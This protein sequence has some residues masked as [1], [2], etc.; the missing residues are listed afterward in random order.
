MTTSSELRPR[1]FCAAVL[2]GIFVAT[3]VFA[4]A[5]KQAHADEVSPSGKGIVG[6]ALLGAEVVTITESLIGVH[7]GWAYLAGA[8]VGGAGGGVGGYFIEQNS[9][10]GKAPVFILAGGLA[11][12]IPAVV[13]SL[14][15]TR[16]RASADASEDSAPKNSDEPANPADSSSAPAA[17]D[18]T[19]PAPAATPAPAAAPAPTPPP[20]SLLDIRGGGIALGLPVPEVRPVFSTRDLRQYGMAQQTELRLPVVHVSF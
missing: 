4:V 16:Y 12:V 8:V 5:P 10:D 9:T 2:S 19:P 14:N 17:K 15:A 6:G 13:L 11:L 3:S 7:N 18:A 20:Q 1:R